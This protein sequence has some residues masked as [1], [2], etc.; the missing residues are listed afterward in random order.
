[1]HHHRIQIYLDGYRL[2]EPPAPI[3]AAGSFVFCPIVLLHGVS[4]PQQLCQWSVYQLAYERAQALIRPSLP[5]RR[6]LECWN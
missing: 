1:M 5:E 2:P 3:P 4:L 6:L